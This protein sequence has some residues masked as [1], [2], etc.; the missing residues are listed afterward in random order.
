MVNGRKRFSEYLADAERLFLELHSNDGD[1][2]INVVGY[3][4]VER[5]SRLIEAGVIAEDLVRLSYIVLWVLSFHLAVFI[6]IQLISELHS[7]HLF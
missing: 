2:G 5:L 1:G 4:I 6:S 7:S 3:A